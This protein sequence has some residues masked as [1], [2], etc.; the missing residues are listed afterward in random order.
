[1]TRVSKLICFPYAGGNA[2][3]YNEL[4]EQLRGRVDV[5]TIE[6]PGRG[7]RAGEALRS[8]LLDLVDD[9]DD[10][11]E[12]HRREPYALFGHSMGA[13]LAWELTRRIAA[14]GRTAPQH[15]F[16]SGRQAPSL[17]N[18]FRRWDLA[19]GEFLDMLRNLGGCPPELLDNEELLEFF[20]PVLRADFEAVETHPAR[21]PVPQDIPMTVLI[22]END[23][24]S[25]D[26]ARAWQR[27]SVHDIS[28]FRLPGN[29][30]FLFDQWQTVAKIITTR[31]SWSPAVERR[32]A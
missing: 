30:F 25:L 22:G 32:L 13:T 2:A 8:R 1:M 28:L 26:E 7:R 21:T 17:P 24:V 14:K 11:S 31:L 4:R 15:V 29:H 20:E 18:K 12:R 19:R 10:A 9:I 27:E 23:E 3:S 6:L 5:V 16:I